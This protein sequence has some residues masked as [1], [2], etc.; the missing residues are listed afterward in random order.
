MRQPQWP[1]W[2]ATAFAASRWLPGGDCLDSARSNAAHARS[3]TGS[4]CSLAHQA[5]KP[6]QKATSPATGLVSSELRHTGTVFLRSG[7]GLGTRER[8]THCSDLRENLPRPMVECRQAHLYHAHGITDGL[9]PFVDAR[10]SAPQPVPWRDSASI[11]VVMHRGSSI[12]RNVS[13]SPLGIAL[14]R[15]GWIASPM[16]RLAVPIRMGRGAAAA[17]RRLLLL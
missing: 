9:E 13:K 16:N 15:A 14:D 4:E 17:A 10:A 2:A 5:I 1:T 8:V 7:G 6:R 3:E 12:T 11:P